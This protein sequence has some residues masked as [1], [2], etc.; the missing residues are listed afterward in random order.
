MNEIELVTLLVA[1]PEGFPL[2]ALG[3]NRGIVIKLADCDIVTINKGMVSVSA[4][5]LTNLIRSLYYYFSNTRNTNNNRNTRKLVGCSAKTLKQKKQAKVSE[6]QKQLGDIL[7]GVSPGTKQGHNIIKEAIPD[8]E[9]RQMARDFE[10]IYNNRFRRGL[11]PIS[12]ARS[13]VCFARAALFCQRAEISAERYLE[14]AERASVNW[15]KRMGVK[16]L[17][18][19]MLPY[20]EEDVADDVGSGVVKNELNAKEVQQLLAENGLGA[21]KVEECQDILSMAK[22]GE[23]VLIET[24]LKREVEWLKKHLA[25]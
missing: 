18:P 6:R 24:K 2:R 9:L 4:N 16:I 20:L 7:T 8:P 10:R 11:K 23:R 3:K 14:T 19:W 1:S 25:K 15:R 17:Q 5:Q 22:L 21:F 12:T 13:K